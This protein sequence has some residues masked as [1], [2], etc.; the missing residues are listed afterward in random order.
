[1]GE[2]EIIFIL[3]CL[4]GGTAGYLRK[5]AGKY[6]DMNARDKLTMYVIELF[7][8]FF[9]A[10]VVHDLAVEFMH[11]KH[12]AIRA[13]TALSAFAGTELLDIIE[14]ILFRYL[15]KWGGN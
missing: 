11:V 8:S 3:I 4:A 7:M 5:T 10:F 9:V 15:D 12:N 2:H 1:M 14:K 6:K 13:F